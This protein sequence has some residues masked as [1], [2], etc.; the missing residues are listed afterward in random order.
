MGGQGFV[1]LTPAFWRNDIAV[2]RLVQP[3]ALTATAGFRYWLV[4]APERRKV[5]KVKRFSEWLLKLVAE[6]GGAPGAAAPPASGVVASA[7][8]GT[9]RR[10]LLDLG[11]RL[12]DIVAKRFGAAAEAFAEE[13]LGDPEESEVVGRAGEAV[14]F[15]GE[16]DVGDR[17]VRATSSR[18]RSARIRRR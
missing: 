5:P 10:A 2:G 15:V 1:L 12:A 14:A 4:T 9:E 8:C 16:D 13:L 18:S 6:S 3:F 17:D 11:G 7:S